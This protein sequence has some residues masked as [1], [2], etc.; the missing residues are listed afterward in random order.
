MKQMN[1]NEIEF[2]TMNCPEN[3]QMVKG[4]SVIMNFPLHFHRRVC[5]GTIEKG[6]A[7]FKG[8]KKEFFLH[9]G[10]VFLV[11]AGE[12]H[13][14]QSID[15]NGFNHFVLCMER[16]LNFYYNEECSKNFR[17]KTSVVSDVELGNRLSSYCE[18]I[19][20][21]E[22][23]LDRECILMNLLQ[24]ISCY[25]VDIENKQEYHSACIHQVCEYISQKYTE[26]FTLSDLANIAH[27]SKYHF[28]RLFKTEIGLTPY[29]YLIQ[30]KI[31]HSKELILKGYSP[32]EVALELGFADQSHFTNLF[33]K[34]TGVTPMIF[35]KKNTI[36]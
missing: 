20:H 5:V 7:L 21:S 32:V 35:L 15:D 28:S 17:F 31:K 27:L 9:A 2:F 6:H 13:T 12:P 23:V 14:L 1:K 26:V 24:D 19:L 4:R 8:N 34:H 16:D 3:L 11:N 30:I 33:K 10:D 29:E 18:Q 36:I 22:C 25:C